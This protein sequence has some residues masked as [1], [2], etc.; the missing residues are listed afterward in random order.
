MRQFGPWF[1]LLFFFLF[2]TREMTDKI[3]ELFGSLGFFILLTLE[4]FLK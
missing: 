1:F 2:K 3:I 4:R